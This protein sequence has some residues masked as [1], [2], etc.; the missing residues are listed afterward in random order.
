MFSFT[1]E[2]ELPIML[3]KLR[4]IDPSAWPKILAYAANKTGDYVLAG[5]KKDMPSFFD[6]P[7]PFTV[8]SMFL[9]LATPQNV[10]ASVQW[11]SPAKGRSAGQY[12]RPEVFGGTRGLKGLESGLQRA[13]LMP[14]G[15]FAVPSDSLQLDQ[16]GNA[17]SSLV[18]TVLKYLSANTEAEQSRRIDK[19][20]KQSTAKFLKGFG[21]T[22]MNAQ[23][24]AKREARSFKKK[25]L[26][27]VVKPGDQSRLYPGVYQRVNENSVTQLFAFV[28]KVDYSATFPFE[29]IGEQ[30]A[31]QKFPEKLNEAIAASLLDRLQRV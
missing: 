24:A 14:A 7:T 31:T 21:K 20:A 12:L 22:A 28:K 3:E 23:R 19:Y 18:R 26:Y 25:A 16:Y 10:E 8:N 1:P 9:K 4:G 2:S 11:K 27:F 15:Y 30:R 13:G 29:K 5:Y 6:R 17:P